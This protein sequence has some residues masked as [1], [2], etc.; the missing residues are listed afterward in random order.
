ML[1]GQIDRFILIQPTGDVDLL[2]V[3]F[4][5]GGLHALLGLNV[6]EVNHQRIALSSISARLSRRLTEATCGDLDANL[7]R[8]L[9]TLTTMLPKS[10]RRRSL[11]ERAVVEL[12][13]SQGTLAISDLGRRL[14]VTPRQLERRFRHEAGLTPKRFARILRFNN[15][16]RL[17][18][19]R[20]ATWTEYSLACGYYDQAHLIRDFHDLAG[21]SPRAFH[22]STHKLADCFSIG[23]CR[24]DF[25]NSTNRISAI[26]ADSLE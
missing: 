2:G 14:G 12:G 26:L 16:L 6:Q 13:A 9:R 4:Q 24:S 7:D 8:V 21:M 1:V 22:R 15:L 25:S 23:Q 17:C 20:P 19:N 18:Q 11:V 10:E 5:P 3:R